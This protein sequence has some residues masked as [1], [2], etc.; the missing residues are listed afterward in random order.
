MRHVEGEKAV[1]KSHTRQVTT[2]VSSRKEKHMAGGQLRMRRLD[3][4][5][6]MALELRAE[7]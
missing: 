7:E 2:A 4:L 3:L 6:K 1:L 5:K